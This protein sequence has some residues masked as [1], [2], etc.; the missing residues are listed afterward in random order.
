MIDI[1][2]GLYTGIFHS[3]TFEI[4]PRRTLEERLDLS[5]MTRR[6]WTR[7]KSEN[8]EYQEGLKKE[9]AELEAKV[10]ANAETEE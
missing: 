1:Q 10:G 9:I 4:F 5:P 3:N 6:A 2:I 8:D 7:A